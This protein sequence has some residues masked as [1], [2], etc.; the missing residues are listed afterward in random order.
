MP[1]PSNG[2]LLSGLPTGKVTLLMSDIEGSTQLLHRLGNDYALALEEHRALLRDGFALHHGVE[3]DAQGD[4]FFAVF[5]DA[6]DALLAASHAQRALAN[7]PWPQGERVRVRVRIGLHTGTPQCTGESY[8]GIDVHHAA[9]LMAAGHGGQTL[10]SDATNVEI[11]GYAL[12]DGLTL[13]A[14]GRHHLKDLPVATEIYQ[15]LLD[16]LPGEVPPLRTP[17]GR[18]HRLPSPPNALI[19]RAREVAQ[20]RE[21]L[22]SSRLLTLTGTGGLGKTRLALQVATETLHEFEGGARLIELAGISD[23]ALVIP[24][25]ASALEIEAQPQH[26]LLSAICKLLQERP[27][28]L[29]LDNCEHLLEACAHFCEVCLR[30][31]PSSRVLATSRELLGIAFETVWRVPTLARPDPQR[32]PD[33]SGVAPALQEFASVQ[34]FLE[35]A[36]TVR[37][38]FVMTAR[39]AGALAE[40]CHRLDGLPLAI[41]LAA[42]RVKM[43]PI[44]GIAQRLDDRFRLLTGGSRS[45][46]PRQ[47][48]LRA[49]IEWSYHLLSP[50]EQCLFRRLSVF[51]GGWTLDA[52]EQVC[53]GDLPGEALSSYDVLDMMS[54]LA[55]A[56]HIETEEGDEDGNPRFRFL[57]TLRDF[58]SEQLAPDERE[59]LR[60]CHAEYFAARL[61]EW[62]IVGFASDLS[63]LVQR[64]A[65]QTREARNLR[66]AIEWAMTHDVAMALRMV[67]SWQTETL[68]ESGA[69]C[70]AMLELLQTRHLEA[71]PELVSHVLATAATYAAWRGDYARQKLLSEQR[72]ALMNASGDRDQA[73]WAMHALGLHAWLTGDSDRA[74]AHSQ[75]SAAMFRRSGA[76]QSLGYVLFLLGEVQQGRSERSSANASYQEAASA[77]RGCGDQDGVAGALALSADLACDEGD[78]ARAH[79]L[80]REV[81]R[82][83]SA[84]G[85]HRA[86]PWRLHQQGRLALLEGDLSSAN[87]LLQRALH[88]F[89]NNAAMHA[90]EK[91]A[92]LRSLVA[93]GCLAAREERWER[94]ALLLSGEA[95]SRVVLGLAASPQWHDERERALQNARAALSQEFSAIWQR[96]QTLSL[97]GAIALAKS[98]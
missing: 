47:Q 10:L 69:A 33:G 71:P 11:S 34:L 98:A 39:N 5:A 24:A 32:L 97:D 22:R 58:A 60:R 21:L 12:P 72:L 38:D 74:L 86:H 65:Q 19:G 6:R 35:R 29:V 1:E 41:E 73:G 68:A 66:A 81:A 55:D 27:A 50:R 79:E 49:L 25:V 84:L 4:A 85:D 46:L 20:V 7:H 37:P 54:H 9:R 45:A 51:E 64:E 91:A 53:A 14:L 15:L 77:L 87:A 31:A 17:E 28:L 59:S 23:A 2:N 95:E 62:S 42:A 52:A 88:T 94:A 57:E 93:L 44:E 8:V 30:A 90:L 18:S 92:L 89:P 40:V 48:T 76:E 26:S 61:Q 78:F 96:G 3:V 75:A 43:L 56:S 83:Q 36:Q 63:Q 13:R 67:A 82:L 80:W 16:D 70:D